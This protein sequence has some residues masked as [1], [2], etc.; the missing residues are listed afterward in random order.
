[1]LTGYCLLT[2]VNSLIAAI[3]NGMFE[4]LYDNC[5]L[6]NDFSN[7][8]YASNYI[9]DYYPVINMAYLIMQESGTKQDIKISN[10]ND[11]KILHDDIYPVYNYYMQEI[12]KK[13]TK[14]KWRKQ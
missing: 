9:S 5:Y 6:Q 4:I 14:K 3:K 11:I 12:Y 13:L 7:Y 1:M 10:I 8:I 2:S